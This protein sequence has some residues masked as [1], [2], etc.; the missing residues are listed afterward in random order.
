MAIYNTIPAPTN[1]ENAL[2]ETTSSKPKSLKRIV[3]GAAARRR[4]AHA[5]DARRGIG[6]STAPPHHPRP[7]KSGTGR[8]RQM[9][10]TYSSENQNRNSCRFPPPARSLDL[11][12][13]A[14]YRYYFREIT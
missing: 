6:P 13:R 3:A 12:A 9:N 1:E 10:A 4:R 5:S 2:L 8:D 11:P 14:A 7:S